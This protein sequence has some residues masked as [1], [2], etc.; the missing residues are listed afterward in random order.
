MTLADFPQLK[1]LPKK[2]RQ[3]LADE[4]WQS[5]VDDASP[6]SAAHRKLLDARWQG[7]QSGNLRAIVPPP[8]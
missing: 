4:L 8:Y 2:D 3:R 1:K 5:S 7:Y 6:V